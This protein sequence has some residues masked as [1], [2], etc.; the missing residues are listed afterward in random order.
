M[1][2]RPSILNTPLHQG[3]DRYRPVHAV[4]HGSLWA[5]GADDVWAMGERCVRSCEAEPGRELSQGKGL[6]TELLSGGNES[7]WHHRG[8]ASARLK[9]TARDL[10]DV[11]VGTGQSF[12]PSMAI[13]SRG[14]SGF[15]RRS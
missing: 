7:W 12:M 10:A 11:E 9:E 3:G 4:A 5:S 8:V 6:P 2:S 1:S 15:L 14:L 13:C